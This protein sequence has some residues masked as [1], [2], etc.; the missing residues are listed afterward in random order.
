MTDLPQDAS[1]P[2][3][4]P[5]IDPET[6]IR[7][8]RRKEGSWVEWGQACQALQK[9]GYSPQTIFEETGFEPTHQN[10]VIVAAQVYA[11]LVTAGAPEALKMHFQQK[12]SDILYELRILNQ[13]E[14]AAVAELVLQ[15]GLNLDEAHEAVKAVKEFS[16]LGK[17]PEH[18]TAHPG[19]AIAYQSWKLARQQADLQA[20]SR[21]IARGL[22]FAHSDSARQQVE[23]L[24]TDFTVVAKT[25]A[26]RLP[27]YRLE[28]AEELPRILPVVGKLPLTKADLQAV[29]IVEPVEPFGMVQFAGEG[30]WVPV[31]GWQVILAAED[32][33]VLM[34]QSDALPTPLEG[35]TETVLVVVD[36]AERNWQIDRYFLVEEAEQLQIQ[37]FDQAPTQPLLGQVV[38]IMRPKKVLD[39]DYTRELW[40][41]DE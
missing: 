18:F 29:P 17:R 7:S 3:F 4:Q 14:R 36:R 8:L 16:R 31:P 33:V 37:W 15:K 25:P 5:T 30:A 28:A 12:G 41:I 10:Q 9:A 32:P 24:L 26:P 23:Q 40:Q 6:L 21:L 11:N 38:L 34:S 19:D 20:R 39:E 35:A 22:R 2:N 1:N 27:V 13:T